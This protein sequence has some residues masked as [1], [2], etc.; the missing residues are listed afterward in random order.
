MTS[1]IVVKKENH[2]NRLDKQ[3]ERS[4]LDEDFDTLVLEGRENSETDWSKYSFLNGWF[5]WATN[6]F[7]WIMSPLYQSSGSLIE[8]ARLK[9]MDI[10]FTRK[11]DYEL[12]ENAPKSLRLFS[13][14][15][16]YG[17]FFT[18]MAYGIYG[19]GYVDSI[20]TPSFLL[21]GAILVPIIILRIYNS[22]FSDSENRDRKIA[23]IIEKSAEN[24]RV[25]A[26]VGGSHKPE[27]FLREKEYTVKEAKATE[28]TVGSIKDYLSRGLKSYFILLSLFLV[29]R[30]IMTFAVTLV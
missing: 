9:D 20:I 16:F 4:L 26:V 29:I 30:E 17:L 23:E 21:L 11:G 6:L 18:S 10:K 25:L 22:K 5:G 8:I 13:L 28:K 24:G 1:E 14:L 15:L 3:E 2:S 27:K 7:F 12:I 19:E